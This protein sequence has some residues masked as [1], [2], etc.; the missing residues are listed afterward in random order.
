VIPQ[1]TSQ[2]FRAAGVALTD[3]PSLRRY[4]DVEGEVAIRHIIPGENLQ[5]VISAGKALAW[6]GLPNTHEALREEVRQLGLDGACLMYILAHLALT[7]DR[8]EISLD[9]LIRAI[10]KGNEARKSAKHREELQR[11]IWRAL[12]LFE[13]LATVGRRKGKYRDRDTK[14]VIDTTTTSVD[15]ILRITGYD[16]A[17][18]HALDKSLPPVVVRYVVG[19]WLERF[20]GDRR[21]LST[22]GD[23]RRLAE[24]PS[25]RAAASWAKSV[26]LGLNQRWREWAHEADVHTVGESNK[27]TVRFP[28]AFT[29]S[30]LL[31]GE[32]LFR[33]DPDPEDILNGPNPGRAIHYWNASIK[34]LMDVGIIGHY[35][36]SNTVST[37]QPGWQR[38]WLFQHLDIRP[39]PDGIK[40][41]SEIAHAARIARR[42]RAKK[43]P[44]S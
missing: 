22:F 43:A 15:A 3:S 42:R 44:S 39:K 25:G 6:L 31:F 8:V 18:Q 2:E 38:T 4:E 9:E 41:I 30:D 17:D 26:G 29:R 21:I 12:M 10:G 32:K 7:E 40:D 34:I 13:N 27:A 20:R 35:E 19:P 37:K 28:Q 1:L 14:E 11:W 16:V 36:E 23:L 24:I 33:A 5:D